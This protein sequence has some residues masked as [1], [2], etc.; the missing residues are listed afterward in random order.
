MYQEK[1]QFIISL[2][3]QQQQKTLQ[4]MEI[5][6]YICVSSHRSSQEEKT[7]THHNN[8]KENKKKY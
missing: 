5:S 6:E 7:H 8:K 1:C 2:A 3:Q 4:S